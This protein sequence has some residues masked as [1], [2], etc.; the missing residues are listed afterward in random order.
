MTVVS[1]LSIYDGIEHT[2][3]F[4]YSDMMASPRSSRLAVVFLQRGNA[5]DDKMHPRVKIGELAGY[6]QKAG[7]SSAAGR[8]TQVNDLAQQLSVPK[9]RIRGSVSE[10]QEDVC[11]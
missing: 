2:V 5:S 3:D 4:Q 1:W 6:G 11:E 10:G 9:G 7:L 8:K